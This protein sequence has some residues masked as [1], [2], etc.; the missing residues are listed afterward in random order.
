MV[1]ELMTLIM[2]LFM[3]INTGE[4]PHNF[5]EVDKK[6]VT[7]VETNICSWREDICMMTVLKSYKRRKGQN[8]PPSCHFSAPQQKN[9]PPKTFILL[10]LNFFDDFLIPRIPSLIFSRF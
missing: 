3:E 10:Q 4:R 9:I 5:L 1:P 7:G 6:G 2:K 8:Q